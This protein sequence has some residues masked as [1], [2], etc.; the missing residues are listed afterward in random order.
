MEEDAFVQVAFDTARGIVAPPLSVRRG[1]ALLYEVRVTNR[2]EI[3]VDPRRPTRGQ[4]AFETDLCIFEE[5]APGIEIPRVVLEF[6]SRLTTHDILTY[7]AKARK[8]KLIYP[9]LRYGLVIANVAT[10]PRRFYTHNEALD[11]CLAAALYQ[12]RDVHGVFARLLSEEIEASRRLEAVSSGEIAANLFRSVIQYEPVASAELP[13]R[14]TP[15]GSQKRA[16]RAVPRAGTLTGRVWEIADAIT[17]RQ[18]RPAR[19]SE[20]LAEY[21]AEGGNAATGATQYARWRKLHGKV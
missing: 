9:Y 18:Q 12:G 17:R 14:R 3:A 1:A 13:R 6:K 20:V 19:R 4:S 16:G 2:L 10:I 7:S 5:T 8:H 15:A 21:E 11:F